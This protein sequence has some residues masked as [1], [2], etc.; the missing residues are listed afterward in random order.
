MCQQTKLEDIQKKSDFF[1][2]MVGEKWQDFLQSIKT[3]GIIEPV[4]LTQDYIVV[5]G[6][7]RV[8]LHIIFVTK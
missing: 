3:S 7:Q 2:D 1:D 6:L 5:S 4:V 8:R